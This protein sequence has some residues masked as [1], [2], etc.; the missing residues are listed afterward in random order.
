MDVVGVALSS[1][2]WNSLMMLFDVQVL[3]LWHAKSKS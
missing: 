2:Y 3:H 1:V